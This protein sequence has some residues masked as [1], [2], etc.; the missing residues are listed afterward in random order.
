MIGTSAIGERHR[1]TEE[2]PVVFVIDDDQLVRDGVNDLLRSIGL[3]VESVWV[4]AGIPPGQ[5]PRCAWLHRT[6]RQIAGGER[7][8]ISTHAGG[9]GH[10]APGDIY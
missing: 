4:S 7:I 8:G 10:P 5:A 1:M 6:R 9:I 3:R 2:Q